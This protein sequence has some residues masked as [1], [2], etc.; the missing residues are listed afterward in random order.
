MGVCL[1]F[2]VLAAVFCPVA[3]TADLAAAPWKHVVGVGEQ[4]LPGEDADT[5]LEVSP[6]AFA[7]LPGLAA[8]GNAL[9]AAMM[10]AVSDYRREDAG[11]S[12]RWLRLAVENGD[13]DSA[14][15]LG[16]LYFPVDGTLG[17]EEFD[18]K[19]N[20]VLGYVWYAIG[21]SGLSS[22][23]E[24]GGEVRMDKEH[25]QE[26]V[27]GLRMLLLPSERVR[28]A[29]LLSTWPE[30][31]PPDTPLE[32]MPGGS[33]GSAGAG[34]DFSDNPPDADAI[35]ELVRE[36]VTGKTENMGRIGVLF[37]APPEFA[38]VLRSAYEKIQAAAD[39]GDSEAEYMAAWCR[40][41]G[42]GTEPDKA[43]AL[44][45]I[46]E[47]AEAGDTGAMF[48]VAVQAFEQKDTERGI[49]FASRAAERGHG[50]AM[51]L[52]SQ[53]WRNRGDREKAAQWMEKAAEAGEW[54]AVQE[55]VSVAESERDWEKIVLWLTVAMIRSPDPAMA[56]RCRMIIAYVGSENSEEEVQKAMEAGERWHKEHP[57]GE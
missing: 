16:K 50:R 34:K 25:A 45:V 2:L 47:R 1:G 23:E 14:F 30:A 53:A 18:F 24:K 31:L 12:V 52:L 9:A 7:K 19:P 46:M 13:V 32:P 26:L 17:R 20:A 40:L 8:E 4:S 37:K 22:V 44:P 3:R 35:V 11:Q 15:A 28:A 29:A 48:L 51:L 36:R 56:Y 33:E 38:P 27:D 54:A 21:L 5:F 39:S 43:A 10:A 55:M 49:E 42:L 57:A 41:Y 6:E